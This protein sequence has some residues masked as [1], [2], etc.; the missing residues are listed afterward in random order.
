MRIFITLLI[1]CI[2]F[3]S[4]AQIEWRSIEQATELSIQTPRKMMVDFY[5]SW[6]GWCKKLDAT[7]FKDSSVVN[8]VNEKFWAVKLNAETRDTIKLGNDN[9]I[10]IPEQKSNQFAHLLLNGKLTYPTIVFI[11]EKKQ[12]LTAVPGYMEAPVLMKVMK[13]FGENEYLRKSWEDYEK[14]YSGEETREK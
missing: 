2:S 6:C 11:D 5:T 13:Y 4:Y 12:I 14:E 1:S 8:Y 7:T 10:Y 9:Y 3:N